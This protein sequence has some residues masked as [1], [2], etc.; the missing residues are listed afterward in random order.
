M[1]WP[2]R[3]RDVQQQP[4][5]WGEADVDASVRSVVFYNV[6]EE[7]REKEEDVVECVEPIITNR[8]ICLSKIS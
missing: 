1:C 5:D 8:K 4:C 7:K 2:A 6:R 3:I